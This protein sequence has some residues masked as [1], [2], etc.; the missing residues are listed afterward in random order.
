MNPFVKERFGQIIA[1]TG[2]APKRALEVG[3]RMGSNSLLRFPELAGAPR[4][5]INLED[6]TSTDGITAVSASANDMSMFDDDSFDLV[7][8]NAT[9]WLCGKSS[10]RA[11]SG[12]RLRRFSSHPE[13]SGSG[14]SRKH[15]AA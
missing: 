11:S 12:S 5:C 15:H 13:S 6:I 8:S 9:R 14:G 4:Y 1:Q 3:G 2:V 10:L 7:M